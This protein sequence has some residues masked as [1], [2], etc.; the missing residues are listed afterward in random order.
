[1]EKL[2]TYLSCYFASL[3]DLEQLNQDASWNTKTTY[4]YERQLKHKIKNMTRKIG[5]SCH[6]L[7]NILHNVFFV[8]VDNHHLLHQHQI[9]WNCV[10]FCSLTPLPVSSIIETDNAESWFPCF[11]ASSYLSCQ[12]LYLIHFIHRLSQQASAICSW[13]VFL[14][15]FSF[16]SNHKPY[17]SQQSQKKKKK[18][19]KP[20]PK[21]LKTLKHNINVRVQ[22][23][24]RL[25]KKSNKR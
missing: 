14:S 3:S 6:I 7:I 25:W 11:L 5:T 10:F 4:I 1:M 8:G 23:L 9:I 13:S 16:P 18:N 24:Y 2:Q 20:Y 17:V 21:A 19:Q 15:K 22:L 12:S